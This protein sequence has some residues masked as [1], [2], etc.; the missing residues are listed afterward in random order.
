MRQ[1]CPPRRS[2]GRSLPPLWEGKERRSITRP[3]G[4]ET[5]VLV[6]ALVIGA[7]L[8]ER[9]GVGLQ[10]PVAITGGSPVLLG[11]PFALSPADERREG[12]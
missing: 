10:T 5:D 1:R 11:N 8:C 4:E 7:G 9:F 2:L 12:P 3:F 6:S